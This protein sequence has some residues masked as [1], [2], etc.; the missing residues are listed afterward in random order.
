M[1]KTLVVI[2]LAALLLLSGCTAV[3]T[4]S[5]SGL[6]A[7][8]DD[9]IVTT[10]DLMRDYRSIGITQ[11]S[12]TGTWLLGYISIVP[13][14]LQ[15]AIKTELVAEA[16]KFGADAVINIQYFEMQYPPLLK[17]LSIFAIISPQYAIVTGE[18]VEFVE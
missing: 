18:L 2:G 14:N 8:G 13:A 12:V 15:D 17:F 9:V 16:G 11:I 3:N 7:N 10:G 4:F 5:V 6:N 1:N